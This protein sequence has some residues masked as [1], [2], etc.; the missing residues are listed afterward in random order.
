MIG[1]SL[2]TPKESRALKAKLGLTFDLMQDDHG[3]L[4]R[5]LGI[6]DLSAWVARPSTLVVTDGK[7]TWAY[8]GADKKDR[9]TVDQIRAALPHAL[10]PASAPARSRF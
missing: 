4:T 8:V 5:A 10:G 9:P 2:D 3:V 6:W 1:V 7:V